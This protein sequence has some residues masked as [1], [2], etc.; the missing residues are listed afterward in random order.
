MCGTIG[1]MVPAIGG[2]I[3]L[4]RLNIYMEDDLE[5]AVRRHA[6]I[7][8]QTLSRWI[9]RACE[10]AMAGAVM[11]APSRSADEAAASH[12]D[13]VRNRRNAARRARYKLRHGPPPMGIWIV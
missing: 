8:G 6:A 7:R 13:A 11:Y 12:E 4:K 2:V 9:G 10:A 3:P 1:G 5:E